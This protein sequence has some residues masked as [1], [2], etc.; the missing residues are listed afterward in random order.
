MYRCNIDYK[1]CILCQKYVKNVPL[2]NPKNVAY[3]HKLSYQILEETLLQ[4]K[5][6]NKLPFHLKFLTDDENISKILSDNIAKWHKSCRL[7]YKKLYLNQSS[8]QNLTDV[9]NSENVQ[10]DSLNPIT[11]N[12][13][14]F[15]CKKV[16][17]KEIL[18]TVTTLDC[19]E[20]ILTTL[21]ILNEVEVLSTLPNSCTM[22]QKYHLKCLGS[23]YNRVRSKSRTEVNK[24]ICPSIESFQVVCKYLESFGKRPFTISLDKIFELYKSQIELRSVTDQSIILSRLQM[25]KKLITIFPSLQVIK[26]GKQCLISSEDKLGN[27]Y[28]SVKLDEDKKNI[29][30]KAAKNIRQDLS[31]HQECKNIELKNTQISSVPESLITLLK[32]II[33]PVDS[34][35]AGISNENL[36]AILTISQVI[37]FNFLKSRRTELPENRHHLASKESPLTKYIGDLIY[38]KTRSSELITKMNTLGLCGTY[39]RVIKRSNDMCNN[40][41]DVYNKNGVVCPPN[42]ASQRFVTGAFDNI[43]YDPSSN[44]AK[45]SFH[46]TAISIN[47]HSVEGDERFKTPEWLELSRVNEDSLKKLPTTYTSIEPIVMNQ[48][49]NYVLNREFELTYSD[50]VVFNTAIDLEHN[51][52]EEVRIGYKDFIVENSNISWSAYHASASQKIETVPDRTALLPM[53]KESSHS[54]EMVA[55]AFKIIESVTNH[56]NPG[57]VSVITCDQPLYAISKQL[58]YSEP[59]LYGMN[60]FVLMFAGMHIEMTALKCIGTW[61]DGSQWNECLTDAN[62]ASS[63]TA[64][65]FLQASSIKKT[66]YAHQITAA[67][68]FILKKQAYLNDNNSCT[69]KIEFNDWEKERSAKYPQFKYWNQTLNF[70]LTIFVFIKSIRSG[71][72]MLYIESLEKLIPWFFALDHVHYA[73]WLS[74]H[75]MDMKYLHLTNPDIYFEFLNGKFVVRKTNNPFSAMALDQCHEQHNSDVKGK[76]GAIG[77]FD[78]PDCLLRWTVTGKLSVVHNTHQTFLIIFKIEHK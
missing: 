15:L 18:R 51:W 31:T 60:K 43:D 17:R 34:L 9:Q 22:N 12:E 6:V 67:A 37:K 26:F 23:L 59:D 32:L 53:F 39:K 28:K 4:F 40:L 1:K 16:Y 74:V 8:V 58:Q 47:T 5:E 25:R 63:G 11:I 62:I 65:S 45:W 75:I 33:L 10:N 66:R 68:L 2:L 42:L 69:N 48:T 77:I 57:Q 7:K 55:H 38:H 78:S 56:L 41:C 73:R 61:L 44:T 54:P 14:C 19:D 20:K 49:T 3:K 36:Q 27:A 71:N 46:G 35:D 70:E 21:R 76:G 29:F 24:S 30:M 13:T 52:L 72:F 50:F 64:H